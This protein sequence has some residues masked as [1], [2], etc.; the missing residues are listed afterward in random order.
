MLIQC[1]REPDFAFGYDEQ[2]PSRGSEFGRN[3][4]ALGLGTDRET[5]ETWKERSGVD[6]GNQ[7]VLMLG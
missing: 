4:L 5:G 1:R 3:S 6:V 7:T 2:L